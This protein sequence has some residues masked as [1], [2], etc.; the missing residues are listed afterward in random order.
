MVKEI[1]EKILKWI[2]DKM[3]KKSDKI[4]IFEKEIDNPGKIFSCNQNWVFYDWK[5][6]IFPFDNL[7]V[8]S[9]LIPKVWQRSNKVK[10]V[11]S[12]I[13]RYGS[14]TVASNTEAYSVPYYEYVPK[15]LVNDIKA[16][17]AYVAKY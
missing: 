7:I 3:T 8:W 9:I 6:L 11:N 10:I 16:G 15:E 5:N 17:Q 4:V 13:K 2:L 14:M 12:K 1:S